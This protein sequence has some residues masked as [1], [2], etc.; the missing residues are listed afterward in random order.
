MLADVTSS[1]FL[2]SSQPPLGP[3][4]TWAEESQAEPVARGGGGYAQQLDV[5]SA[6]L[7]PAEESRLE[8]EGLTMVHALPRAAVMYKFTWNVNYWLSVTSYFIFT[9]QPILAQTLWLAQTML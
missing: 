5:S 8:R 4:W 6:P 9:L 7:I 3:S 1:P 2:P